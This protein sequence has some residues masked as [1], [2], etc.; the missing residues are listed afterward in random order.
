MLCA[1]EDRD[2]LFMNQEKTGVYKKIL[3][4][5]GCMLGLGNFKV[6]GPDSRT[7]AVAGALKT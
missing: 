7:S 3:I 2:F 4:S 1:A 6:C 5:L